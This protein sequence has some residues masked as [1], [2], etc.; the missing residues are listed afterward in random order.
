MHD[1]LKHLHIMHKET[2]SLPDVFLRDIDAGHT[3][4]EIQITLV[5]LHL[6]GEQKLCKAWSSALHHLACS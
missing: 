5:S 2:T 3:Y 4:T 1:K 6:M